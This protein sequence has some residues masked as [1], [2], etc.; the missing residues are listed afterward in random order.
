MFFCG[1]EKKHYGFDA[2]R[3][4]GDKIVW[5]ANKNES[6]G[7]D[8]DEIVLGFLNENWDYG[9]VTT[10]DNGIQSV[11]IKTFVWNFRAIMLFTWWWCQYCEVN[12]RSESLRFAHSCFYLRGVKLEEQI[13]FLL[14]VGDVFILS[15]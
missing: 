3:K 11:L 15:L 6:F 14:E 4:K 13:F 8:K 5:L 9:F 12:C 7:S 10:A 1:G 2:L